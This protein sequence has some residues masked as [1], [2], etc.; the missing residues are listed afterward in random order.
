MKLIGNVQGH[1]CAYWGHALSTY[2]IN[3]LPNLKDNMLKNVGETIAN[4]FMNKNKANEKGKGNE[5]KYKL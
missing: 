2:L 5:D 4:D 1:T 3:I